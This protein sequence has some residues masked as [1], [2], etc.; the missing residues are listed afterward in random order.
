MAV[1]II[2]VIIIIIIIVV[3]SNKYVPVLFISQNISLF[4]RRKPV[5]ETSA[6]LDPLGDFESSSEKVEL[7]EL[8]QFHE[9]GDVTEKEK[10]IRELEESI[11]TPEPVS[12]KFNL[13]NDII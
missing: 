8:T 13:N 6:Y 12:C 10:E 1:I 9:N 7:T 4:Y 3:V 2:I 5:I 11:K